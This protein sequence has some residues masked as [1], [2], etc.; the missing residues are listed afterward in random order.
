ME[1]GKRIVIKITSELPHESTT[2]HKNDVRVKKLKKLKKLIF[3]FTNEEIKVDDL[4]KAL[5]IEEIRQKLIN[6]VA[7]IHS[8]NL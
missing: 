3:A 5:P 6:K 4:K 1:N 2:K 8:K 7:Y